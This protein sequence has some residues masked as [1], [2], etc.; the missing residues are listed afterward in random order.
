ME[1]NQHAELRA[2]YAG[3]FPFLLIESLIWFAS[4][5]LGSLHSTRAAIYTL[6]IGGVLIAP[7]AEAIRSM[8]KFPVLPKTNRLKSLSVQLA[9]TIPLGY[10][11]I[12][13]AAAANINWLFPAFCIT[14]GAHFL[15]FVYLYQMRA[16]YFIAAVFVA[17]GTTIGYFWRDDFSL[18]GY[19]GGAVLLITAAVILALIKRENKKTEIKF[20][21]ALQKTA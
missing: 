6:V 16:F 4:A 19:F 7:L 11:L 1:S 20:S 17:G 9:L 10:P 13:A 14:V 8:M 15:P 3:G 5:A 18:A 2:S 21:P 12:A